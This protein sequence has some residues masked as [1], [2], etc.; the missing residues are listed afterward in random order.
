M[1][2]KN[3][4]KEVHGKGPAVRREKNTDIKKPKTEEVSAVKVVDSSEVVKAKKEE[5][6]YVIPLGGL[7]EVGKNM[8]LVQYRDEIIILDAGLT[9]P[10]DELLGIDLVIPDFS[11]IESNK[12][13]IKGLFITHGHEDHIGGI[14]YLYN[15]IDKSVPMYGGK[16]TLALAKSKFDNPGFS[17]VLPKMKEIK[18][19]SK[20]KVG[21]YFTVEFIKVTHSI[22]DAY[23]LAI[24][25]PAGVI[26]HTGDF[27]IDLTPVDGVGVDFSRLAQLGDQGV[28][29]LLSDSTN[30]EVEGFTPSEKSVGE[31]FR[32]EFEKAKGRIIAASFASHIHRL[33]Q[34]ID[35][36]HQYK[37]K[38]AIDGRSMVRVFEI[39]SKLGYLKIPEGLMVSL[40]EVGKLKEDKV[41][42]LCT[43][44]QGEPLAALSRIAKDMHKHIKLRKGDTVIISAT[45]IPGNERAVYNNINNLLK[46]DAEVVFRKI[47]GI[48]VSGHASKDEQKLMLNLIKPRHFMPVHGEYK[49]LKAHKQTAIE[50]GVVE[51]KILI[52]VNGSKI[53]VTK[54]YAKIAGKVSAGAILVDGLGV[55]DI[56]NIVLRD[57]QQL[58][59]DGVVI[60]VLTISK[61]TGMILAGPDIVTRGFVY[62]RESEK[63]INEAALC[64]KEKLKSYEEKKITEWAALKTVTKDVASKYFYDKIQRNPVI[65]PIIMEV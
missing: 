3:Q 41:V 55:G 13:K 51:K 64:I 54:S 63:M 36:A 48:H 29:L 14:P 57:R 25:T 6:M 60:V 34:I 33:Q 30:S 59:Q 4:Q 5:K 49:M 35:V 43:G 65:L 39:A 21:K 10:D 27:K 52:A 28:D 32:Q 56:G 11:Y 8:T 31:A 12:N 23:A 15:K 22:A 42:I 26:V 2:I 45:P 58:G 19:R 50:T 17:K 16:L 46:H 62:S 7:D 37:R 24:T 47:A 53:E 44:T 38:I 9:F 61:E 40:H 18:G 1:S 20:I